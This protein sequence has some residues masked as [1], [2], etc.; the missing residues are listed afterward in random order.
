MFIVHTATV[1]LHK[2]SVEAITSEKKDEIV[3]SY[4]IFEIL[5]VLEMMDFCCSQMTI[6]IESVEIILESETTSRSPGIPVLALN[7]MSVI[8]MFEWTGDVS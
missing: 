1:P 3:S 5:L 6:N 2:G 7:I 8:Q 4:H